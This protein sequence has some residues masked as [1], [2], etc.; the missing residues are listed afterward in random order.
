MKINQIEII[1]FHF[2]ECQGWATERISRKRG[3][4]LITSE[5]NYLLYSVMSLTRAMEQV[6]NCIRYI[7]TGTNPKVVFSLNR[8]E[9]TKLYPTSR[10]ILPIP[11]KEDIERLLNL[12]ID[13][14]SVDQKIIARLVGPMRICQLFLREVYDGHPPDAAVAN[15][16]RIWTDRQTEPNDVHYADSLVFFYINYGIF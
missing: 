4:E 12:F 14:S 10:D 7:F 3:N 15:A 1:V 13:V 9:V 6:P 8:D 2:D 16:Y 11:K 5:D